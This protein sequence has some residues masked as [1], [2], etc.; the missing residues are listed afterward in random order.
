[1]SGPT[2]RVGLFG[3]GRAGK[4]VAEEIIHADGV[5][6]AWVATRSVPFT[7]SVSEILAAD[8]PAQ[9]CF[10]STQSMQ[11][12][13]LLSQNPVDFI[14]DFSGAQT[15]H[16][17]GLAAARAG[18]GIVSAVSHYEDDEL[19]F[20]RRLGA[21]TRVLHSP[22]ITVGIN[23]LMLAAKALQ[24]IAPHAD[25]EV[26]EQHFR[27]KC[28]V[29]GTAMRLAETLDL[30]SDRQV[31]SI[32]VGGIIGKHE[33]IFGFPYQTIR[34]VHES[35]ARNAFGQGAIYAIS[36][37]QACSPGFH[38]MEQLMVAEFQL[39]LSELVDAA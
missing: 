2:I 25:I 17:Y 12:D 1:M 6:L 11:A 29:S 39:M 34:L 38:T 33:V 20:L 36:R 23:F 16:Y 22:N 26:I 37:L 3:F 28:E 15:V 13:L 10:V 30:D 21:H 8:V 18:I 9:G 35:I 5:D 24:R 7:A 19:A 27:D 4:A 32:R 31:N 14:V